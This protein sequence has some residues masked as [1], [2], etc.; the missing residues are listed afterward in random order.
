MKR[1]LV[2]GI[3]SYIGNSF[4]KYMKQFFGEYAIEGIS[5]RNGAWRDTDFSGYDCVFHV[6]GIAHADSG[7]I[8]EEKARLYFSINRDMTIEIAR[9]AKGEGVRQFIFMSSAIVYG[10]SAPIG[11][12]KIISSN[13]KPEP[14]SAYSSSKLQA[15]EG[16]LPLDDDSFRVVILRPPMI[17]GPGCKGN[18][19]IL[20]SLARRLPAFPEISNERSMLYVEN[21]SEFVRLM[22]ENEE[23]GIFFPQ[24]AEYSNTSDLVRLIAEVHGRK[25]IPLRGISFLLKL[26]SQ[27][28]PLVNKAFGSLSYEMELSEYKEDYRICSLRESIERT[29]NRT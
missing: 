13:T 4:M 19:P 16:I 15:E 2:T 25:I 29:E 3:N 1:I 28:S 22:I 7:K 17:Y 11:K 18:Y 26:M 10:E 27:F 5:C 9:K 20:S 6:A 24:N 12:K 21:L 14:H 8:T 23:H